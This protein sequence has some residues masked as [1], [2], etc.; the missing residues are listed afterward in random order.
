MKSS[1]A[2]PVAILAAGAAIVACSPKVQVSSPTP[3]GT[4]ATQTATAPAKSSGLPSNITPAM[5]D[6]GK[7]LF[8]GRCQRCHGPAGAGGANGPALN[9]DK[10]NQPTV[11]GSYESIRALIHT[12]VPQTSIKGDSVPGQPRKMFPYAMRP[13]GGGTYNDDQL[14]MLAAYVYTLSHK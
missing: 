2:R 7:A 10:W 8:A 1:F 4:G 14:S 9:D 6:S 11:N 13:D 3:A 5:V 12:G